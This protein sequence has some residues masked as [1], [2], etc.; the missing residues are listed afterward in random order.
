VCVLKEQLVV[1]IRVTE[2]RQRALQQ[3]KLYLKVVLPIKHIQ[4]AL[5]RVFTIFGQEGSPLFYG[6]IRTIVIRRPPGANVFWRV[7]TGAVRMLASFG[8]IQQYLQA[9]QQE[10]LPIFRQSHH[11]TT[12][13]NRHL[14][15]LP[16]FLAIFQVILQ[17]ATQLSFPLSD[18]HIHQQPYLPSIRP[19]IQQVCQL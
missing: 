7:R 1:R 3:I 4:I 14:Y 2:Q 8:V 13:Q 18:R 9:Y 11:P 16:L 10:G 17:L 19:I 6:M 12:R 5:P 15:I